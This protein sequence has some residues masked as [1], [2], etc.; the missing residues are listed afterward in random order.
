MSAAR[1]P[2][3]LG[4][5]LH[6]ATVQEAVLA[7]LRMAESPT[8]GVSAAIQ[9]EVVLMNLRAIRDSIAARAVPDEDMAA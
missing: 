8:P 5:A 3:V 2:I 1:K 7:V 4:A 6:Y 9:L